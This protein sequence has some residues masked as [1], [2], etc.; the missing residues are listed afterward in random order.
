[1][2][3]LLTGSSIEE[4]AVFLGHSNIRT[5]Q[6]HYNPWVFERRRQFEADVERAWAADPFLQSVRTHAVRREELQKTNL[7]IMGGKEM[8]PAV[9]IEPTA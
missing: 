7:F 1:V 5:T 4:V 3:L 8:V 2:D 6:R 9:G